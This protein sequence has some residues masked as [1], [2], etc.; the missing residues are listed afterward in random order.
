MEEK[1][2]QLNA[3]LDQEAAQRGELNV[4]Y[5]TFK[6]KVNELEESYSS[7]EASFQSALSKCEALSIERLQVIESLKQLSSQINE[8]N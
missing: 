4:K 2:N 8:L 1:V 6:S 7:L 3:K 5:N